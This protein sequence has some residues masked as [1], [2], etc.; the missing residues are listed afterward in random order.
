[1]R[2][3]E[4][5]SRPMRRKAIEPLALTMDPAL[6][7]RLARE[8]EAMKWERLLRAAEAAVKAVVEAVRERRRRRWRRGSAE[9]SGQ[10][11][12]HQGVSSPSVPVELRRLAKSIP[13]RYRCT[14]ARLVLLHLVNPVG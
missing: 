9:S 13:S 11:E 5:L 4:P 3:P 6:A 8:R 14:W 1:M 2:E 12:R 7:E 10:P